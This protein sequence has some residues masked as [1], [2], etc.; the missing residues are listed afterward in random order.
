MHEVDE[1]FDAMMGDVRERFYEPLALQRMM[2]PSHFLQGT[3]ATSNGLLQGRS[4]ID[5]ALGIAQDDTQ[6][7]V[8]LDV[9]GAKA[10]DINLQLEEG[11][12]LLKISGETKREEGGIAV[13]SRFERSIRLSR[14]IDTD[15]VSAR[16][17]GGVLTI[18]VLKH[19][20]SSDN[21]R[22][23][24][25]IENKPAIDESAERS[26]EDGGGIATSQVNAETQEEVKTV[27]DES[28]IDLD[29]K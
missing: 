20:E 25:I 1:M 23:I 26:G 6:F 12:R 11:G 14:D 4:S 27:A 8:V 2:R 16:L 22:R 5:T 29:T 28:V 17:E 19:Q 24:D 3:P 13:H 18:T 15:H 7:Q 21:I 10:S 9:P